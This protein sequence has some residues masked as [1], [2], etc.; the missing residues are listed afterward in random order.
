MKVLY[1]EDDSTYQLTIKRELEALNANYEIFIA[2]DGVDGIEH[3]RIHHPDIIISDIHMPIMDG[4]RIVRCIREIDNDAI[5]IITSEQCMP[6]DVLEGYNAGAQLYVKKPFTA[7]ELNAQI[8]SLF[9]LKNGTD[10]CTNTSIRI[11]DLLF[12]PKC[13]TLTNIRTGNLITISRLQADILKMLTDLSNQVVP[14][15]AI[16]SLFWGDKVDKRYLDSRLNICMHRLRSKLSNEFF[17]DVQTIKNIGYML[18]IIKEK[19]VD[20]E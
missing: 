11:G 17:V 1:I 10:L 8:Q 6:E 7:L 4:L 3:W 18:K 14:R 19:K 13:A 2:N 20:L 9:K 5:I 16:L 15:N 12:V